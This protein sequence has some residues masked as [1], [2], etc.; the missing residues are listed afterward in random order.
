MS[1]LLES[2]TDM[3]VVGDVVI[4]NDVLG[5]ELEVSDGD[6]DG[7]TVGL[8]VG[9]DVRSDGDK[10]SVR[11]EDDESDALSDSDHD[12]D[13][14]FLDGVKLAKVCVPESLLD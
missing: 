4:D 14:V 7:E 5:E 12:C 3:V 8:R 13:L 11:L 9:V 6:I 1:R 2:V 10:D